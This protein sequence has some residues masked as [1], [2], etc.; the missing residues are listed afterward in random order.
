MSNKLS[1]SRKKMASLGIKKTEMGDYEYIDE[2]EKY[3][4]KYKAISCKKDIINTVEGKYKILVC[5]EVSN[6]VEK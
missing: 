6:K 4:S 5:E 1:S 3:Q 2:R